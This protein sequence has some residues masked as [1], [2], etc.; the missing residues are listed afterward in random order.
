MAASEVLRTLRCIV[1]MPW[2]M[3]EDIKVVV[4]PL[5]PNAV[6]PDEP[7]QRRPIE[8]GQRNGDTVGFA[9]V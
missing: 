5:M 3:P 1:I 9:L 6:G 7:G 8:A 4:E 2:R